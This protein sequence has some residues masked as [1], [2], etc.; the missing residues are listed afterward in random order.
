MCNFIIRPIKS[1]ATIDTKAYNDETK[2]WED[3]KAGTEVTPK[4][5]FAGAVY[6]DD[7]DGVERTI[8]LSDYV[9]TFSSNDPNKKEKKESK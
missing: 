7:K 6:Y 8:N 5:V 9:H 3:V 2:Q 4:L 1:Y